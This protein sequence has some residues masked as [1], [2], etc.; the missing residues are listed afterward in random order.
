M[1]QIY[2]NCANHLIYENIGARPGQSDRI[3]CAGK[4]ECQ[5]TSFKDSCCRVDLKWES[6]LTET[7]NVVLP[8]L[9]LNVLFKLDII[10]DYTLSLLLQ[11]EILS[12][13]DRGIVIAHLGVLNLL[14]G[15]E[16]NANSIDTNVNDKY[17]KFKCYE[18]WLLTSG[19]ERKN[20]GLPRWT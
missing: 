6:T 10:P 5:N 3:D 19:N 9:A 12:C 13:G 18:L 7:G 2:E 15:E 11:L 4:L 1:F 14:S 20:G 8:L 17:Q 16:T